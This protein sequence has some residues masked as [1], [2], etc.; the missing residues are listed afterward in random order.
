MF[1]RPKIEHKTATQRRNERLARER[2]ASLPPL[3]A[4]PRV[5]TPPSLPASPRV[6][7]PPIVA[8]AKPSPPTRLPVP[9]FASLMRVYHERDIPRGSEE[10]LHTGHIIEDG[11]LM[12]DFN[13]EYDAG[14]YYTRP[15]F[16]ELLKT[17]DKNPYTR[18]KFK[19]WAN[20]HARLIGSG[21]CPFCEIKVGGNVQ[22]SYHKELK[23]FKNY[24]HHR[25]QRMLSGGGSGMYFGSGK[26]SPSQLK[27]LR[28]AILRVTD[29]IDAGWRE[30]A[31]QVEK[32]EPYAWA[33]GTGDTYYD[34]LSPSQRKALVKIV[35]PAMKK[36]EDL[37]KKIYQMIDTQTTLA[38]GI[39]EEQKLRDEEQ[40]LRDEEKRMIEM[41]EPPAA[42][43]RRS[44]VMPPPPRG[45][46]F[47]SRIPPPPPTAPRIAPSPP[48]RKR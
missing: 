39:E 9:S 34:P 26:H 45:S 30:L 25:Q 37:E 5:P 35:E 23:A 27:K 2:V 6:P 19:D 11:E 29:D 46:P 48:P 15:T 36:K 4:S 3:P 32:L 24:L 12:T 21:I 47:L 1:G 17:S 41:P 43:P 18:G 42:P 22:M 20:Y 33:E 38:K 40:K 28:E 31:Q 14:R 7:T 16:L 44:P 10:A 8:I 13:R